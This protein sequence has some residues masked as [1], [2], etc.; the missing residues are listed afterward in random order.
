RHLLLY[1]FRAV[2]FSVWVPCPRKCRVGAN[3]PSRWPTMFSLMKAGTC[4]RPSCTAMVC[5]TMSG[6][7]TEARAQVRMIFL[8]LVAFILS[9]LAFSCGLMNGPFLSER[10]TYF[11]LPFFSRRRM[12]SLSDA[13]LG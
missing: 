13:F 10:D 2:D 8:S 9:T 1:Y 6:K 7:I 4:L 11:F 12:I 3:S 5:P